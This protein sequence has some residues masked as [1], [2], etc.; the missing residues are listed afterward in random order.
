MLTGQCVAGDCLNRLAHVAH[1]ALDSRFSADVAARAAVRY[2]AKF[3]HDCYIASTITENMDQTRM[4][5]AREAL[6]LK[7]SSVDRLLQEERDTK[8]VSP[9]GRGS[10]AD[11]S[12]AQRNRGNGNEALR[13]GLSSGGEVCL[14]WCLNICS[15]SE[16][17]CNKVHMCPFCGSRTKGCVRQNHLGTIVKHVPMR[18]LQIPG[19]KGG[20]K[21]SRS[22]SRHGESDKPR[23]G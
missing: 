12:H 10:L 9:A 20:R 5:F 15:K 3:M 4:M 21:R 19:G 1:I 13:T 14:L 8:A 18:D 17:H 6:Q 16:N 11:S 22:R 2:D 23:R 7:E